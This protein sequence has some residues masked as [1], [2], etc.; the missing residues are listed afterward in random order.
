M[1]KALSEPEMKAKIEGMGN[2]VVANS[3]EEFTAQVRRGVQIFGNV[4]KQAGL[5]PEQ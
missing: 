4:V 5:K 3:P 2:H 1:V